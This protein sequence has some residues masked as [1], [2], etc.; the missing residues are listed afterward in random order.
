[1]KKEFCD[2]LRALRGGESQSAFA[3][4][5]GTKQTT[6]SAWETGAREPDLTTLCAIAEKTGTS[7]N[8]LLGF[9][10]MPKPLRPPD[11]SVEL[12][13]EIEAILRKY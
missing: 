9:A 3:L 13:K 8:E 6:Y 5:I 12:K 4:K 11:R 10:P 1:M 2:R 7:P